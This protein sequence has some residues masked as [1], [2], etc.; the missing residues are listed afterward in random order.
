MITKISRALQ[1]ASAALFIAC[2]PA[3]AQMGVPNHGVPV[4]HGPGTGTFNTVGPCLSGIAIVGAGVSAD[5]ACGPVNL[6]TGVTGN[7]PVANLNSGSGASAA[8]Y[9]RGD[10]TWVT[11]AGAG[12]VTS[13][14]CN[15]GVTVI[16]GVGTCPSPE[17]LSGNRTYFVRV[18]GNDTNC[19]GLTN[20]DYVSGVF[21]QACGF[22]TV[23]KAVNVSYATLNWAGFTVTAQLADG[24]YTGATTITGKA[25]GQTTP[26]AIVGNVGTPNNVLIS[27][28]SADGFTITSHAVASITGM[29]IQTTTGGNCIT[30]Q[31][32]GMLT[33]GKVNY[34]AS[35][36]YHVSTAYEAFTTI[37]GQSYT[38]SGGA[39]AHY[40]TT[41][42]SVLLSISNTITLSG[43]PGFATAFLVGAVNSYSHLVGTTFSGAATGLRF[44]MY[45]NAVY[46][47]GSANS[48][49]FLPGNAAGNGITQAG[50]VYNN[51][52][53]YNSWSPWAPTI[54]TVSG[55]AATASGQYKLHGKDLYINIQVTVSAAGSSGTLSVPLPT[56]NNFYNLAP[57][58]AAAFTRA[59]TCLNTSLGL[60]N[61]VCAAAINASNTAITLAPAGAGFATQTYTITGLIEIQ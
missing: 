56:A 6:A 38:I 27:T 57:V 44:Y 7:L 18:A 48:Y 12:T 61:S 26:F 21:P 51:D 13:V 16:T 52:Y 55:T 8:T 1:V 15:N 35:A 41:L 31:N 46:S 50:A 30:N 59:L 37:S 19:T 47:D 39:T 20:A 54:A 14:T 29:K 5:P 60:A 4:S 33:I 45:M 28:T 10:G 40:Y 17:T 22:A 58:T 2:A 23:Q 9:W 53:E 24:T 3:L 25:I 36:G 43:T 49:S 42:N 32:G 11:P 34:G